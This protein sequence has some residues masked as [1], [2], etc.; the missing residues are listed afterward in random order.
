MY[1]VFGS[2]D[3]RDYDLLVIVDILG[4]TAEN[5]AAGKAR[6]V[7]F[8]KAYKDKPLNVN[9]A[10]MAG[11]VLTG[12]FKGTVD[13]VNNSIIDTYMLHKQDYVLALTKRLERDKGLKALRSMRAM[14]SFMSRTQFRTPIKDALKGAAVDKYAL[15]KEIDFNFI[16]DLG[17]KI[18]TFPDF[19]KTLAFQMGQSA[20]L[21]EGVELYTKGSIAERYP[22]LA[23][24][25]ERQEYL[26]AAP[27]LTKFK[28]YWLGTFDPNLIPQYEPGQEKEQ[29]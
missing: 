21:N 5:K 20:A 9:L 15:L 14:L 27:E 10:T 4:T 18:T 16:S 6:E 19:Y 24:M 28:T 11:G 1:Y 17:H 26:Q 7:L 12:V 22:A 23:P 13:E 3:S 8:S 2:Q 29:P 25:L